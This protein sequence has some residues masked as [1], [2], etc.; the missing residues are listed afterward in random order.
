MYVCN[1]QQLENVLLLIPHFIAVSHTTDYLLIL[2]GDCDKG[3]ICSCPKSPS[4]NDK[5]VITARQ[6]YGFLILV[7]QSAYSYTHQHFTSIIQKIKSCCT[8]QIVNPLTLDSGFKFLIWQSLMRLH[9]N[10]VSVFHKPGF[11]SEIN[12]KT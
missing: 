5:R 1:T 7:T 11:V 12:C 3:H 10:R 2:L 4:L 8:S 6:K 9:Q